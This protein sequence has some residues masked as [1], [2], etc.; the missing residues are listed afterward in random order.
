[1]TSREFNNGTKP[2]TK[3]AEYFQTGKLA[4]LT[5]YHLY[6]ETSKGVLTPWVKGL[7]LTSLRHLLSF[8]NPA[9]RAR[10]AGVQ[11]SM[12]VQYSNFRSA[13]YKDL[14][15]AASQLGSI[16]S[17][18]SSSSPSSPS[19]NSSSSS[20]LSSSISSSPSSSSSSSPSSSSSSSPSSSSSSSSSHS[21]LKP[22]QDW[23][24]A[25]TTMW[26]K[27]FGTNYESYSLQANDD[28]LNGEALL[29]LDA[30]S[31]CDA[32]Q[33]KNAIHLAR[34]TSELAKLKK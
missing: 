21:L 17:S 6:I 4:P 30:R 8:R 16:P 12:N 10:T 28:G 26:L 2:M 14:D 23:T 9:P 33:V 24:V 31:L 29:L 19:S 11:E 15:A 13:L 32:L 3:I 22:L 18:S 1:M 20:T 5:V 7:E 25:D 27:S 34:I